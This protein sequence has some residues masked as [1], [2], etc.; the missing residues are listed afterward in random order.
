[1]FSIDEGVKP[2]DNVIN[3]ESERIYEAIE[4]GVSNAIWLIAT[5]ATSAPCGD[6]YHHIQQGVR[7]GIERVGGCCNCPEKEDS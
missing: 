4:R 1:M 5:N 2:Q 3:L 7:D 6:F